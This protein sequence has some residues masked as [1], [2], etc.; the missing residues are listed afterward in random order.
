MD[1]YKQTKPDIFYTKCL[2]WFHSPME[3]NGVIQKIIKHFKKF[4]NKL[5]KAFKADLL[6]NRRTC[7][8]SY[9]IQLNAFLSKQQPGDL[10][11]SIYAK[12]MVSNKKH[13]NFLGFISNQLFLYFYSVQLTILLWFY[14]FLIKKLVI[15]IAKII[16]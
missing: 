13:F 15:L 2:I 9:G 10:L 8:N 14:E 16:V 11:W 4:V 7:D 12:I 1:I 3:I 5:T 6:F